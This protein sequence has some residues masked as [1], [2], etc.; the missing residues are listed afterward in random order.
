[1]ISTG[2]AG[3]R[4]QTWTCVHACAHPRLGECWGH[5]YIDAQEHAHTQTPVFSDLLLLHV[6][7]KQ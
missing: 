1:M 3:H 7:Y 4:R 5:T 2:A 6:I